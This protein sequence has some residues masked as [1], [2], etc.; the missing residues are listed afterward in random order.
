[1][2]LRLQVRLKPREAGVRLMER[3][4]GGEER[5]RVSESVRKLGLEK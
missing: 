4:G 1:M 3:E 2:W 5:D